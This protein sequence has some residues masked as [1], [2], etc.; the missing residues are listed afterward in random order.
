MTLTNKKPFIAGNWKLNKTVSEALELISSLKEACQGITEA[1]IVAIPPFTALNSVASHIQDSPITLGAQNLFWEDNG[2]F[3]G[4]ISAS[5]LVDVGC[6]YVVIG[7][8]ERRQHFDETNESVNKKIRAALSHGLTP[9]FCMGESLEERESGKTMGKVES[10]ILEG[11]VG[12]E[13]ED[14][15]KIVFAYEPIWAI[16]TGL[17]ASPDQAED[18]HNFIRNILAEKY[19]N[20]VSSCAIILYG[21]SV[22]PDSTFSLLSEK[23]INGVLVGGASLKA[24]SFAE[25]IKEG[26]RAYKEK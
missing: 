12:I 3:T 5:M 4:E 23:D 7:H 17:T 25:I 18:I 22:K 19:G 8:S 14:S 11:L 2:A 16:G 20:D 26:I 6:S 1:E 21:G 10:Q 24:D 15:R 9:I 13:S